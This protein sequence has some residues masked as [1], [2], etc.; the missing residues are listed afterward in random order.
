MLFFN[1]RCGLVP[2]CAQKAWE[3]IPSRDMAAESARM[4]ELLSS[5]FGEKLEQLRGFNKVKAK[6]GKKI[7]VA[8]GRDFA[9]SD[10]ET[11]SS[12]SSSMSEHMSVQDLSEPDLDQDLEDESTL[13]RDAPNM[14]DLEEL[15]E[16]SA[17]PSRRRKPATTST[18]YIVGQFV[19]AVYSNMWYIAQ[20]EGEEE[21]EELPG[22]T[23]LR[24]MNRL[25]LST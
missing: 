5:T 4:K 3:R 16:L 21:D 20:V 18:D 19:A 11:A 6:R 8:P 25:V 10:D 23:L 7:Q 2:V 14:D 9:A 12:S 17:I 1:F 15:P 22:Y 24:Y 13:E